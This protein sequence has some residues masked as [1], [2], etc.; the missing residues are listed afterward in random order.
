[1]INTLTHFAVYTDDMERAKKFYAE[2]F[3]W[4]YNDY[5]QPDF[6][7]IKT[8]ETGELIG[9]LQSTSFSPISEKIIG[10]ECTIA[11]ADIDEVIKR[12]TTS[13]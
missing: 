1:M 9:A 4:K 2:V 10:F 7:Q 12:V 3:Q 6:A 13:G 5:G 11:V 8:S